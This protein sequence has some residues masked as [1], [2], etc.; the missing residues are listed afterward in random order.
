V[1]YTLLYAQAADNV[2]RDAYPINEKIAVQ[3]AA[4]RAQITWGDCSGPATASKL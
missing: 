3:L 4:L 2:I 1:E